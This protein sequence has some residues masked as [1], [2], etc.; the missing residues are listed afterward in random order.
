MPVTLIIEDKEI[1]TKKRRL[2]P[3]ILPTSKSLSVSKRWLADLHS[4]KLRAAIGL[5]VVI[6]VLIAYL[7]LRNAKPKTSQT[8]PT[9]QAQV[10]I[11][12]TG[13]D[14]QTLS[15]KPHTMVT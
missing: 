13:F 14:P 3:Q 7:G 10:I 12:D 5:A 2:S 1:K 6:L 9:Y 11:T 4:K 15:V 8:K